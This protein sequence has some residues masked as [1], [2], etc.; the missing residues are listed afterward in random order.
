[1]KKTI[2]ATVSSVAAFLAV[3]GTD[4]SPAKPVKAQTTINTLDTSH[5]EAVTANN[6]SENDIVVVKSGDSLNSIASA[7]HITVTDIYNFN[8]GVTELIHPGT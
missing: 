2:T 6:Y 3:N 8:P 4:A 7:H 5:T 1:M